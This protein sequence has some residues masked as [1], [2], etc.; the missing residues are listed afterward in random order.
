MSQHRQV[1]AEDRGIVMPIAGEIPRVRRTAVGSTPRV[2]SVVFRDRADLVTSSA[3]SG[4]ILWYSVI[5]W[6]AG[7]A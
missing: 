2:R 7:W 3:D 5:L 6:Y 4:L 1:F